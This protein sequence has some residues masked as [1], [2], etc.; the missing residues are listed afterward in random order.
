MKTH[1]LRAWRGWMVVGLTILAPALQAQDELVRN[2]HGDFTASLDGVTWSGA[3]VKSSSRGVAK[4]HFTHHNLL[5]IELI[6][7]LKNGQNAPIFEADIDLD[8]HTARL[9]RVDFH[10]LFEPH[11][12]IRDQKL[13][14]HHLIDGPVFLHELILQLGPADVAVSGAELRHFKVDYSVFYDTT[15]RVRIHTKVRVDGP[16]AVDGRVVGYSDWEFLAQINLPWQD[17]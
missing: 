16:K 9:R 6:E 15:A 5:H 13:R 1:W 2:Q 11:L 14:Q 3:S 4:F 17:D 12:V 8:D 10:Q 7:S